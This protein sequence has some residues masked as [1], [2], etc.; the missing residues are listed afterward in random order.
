[1]GLKL[2]EIYDRIRMV[3]R[4]DYP[5]EFII[6]GDLKIELSK[7]RLARDTMEVKFVFKKLS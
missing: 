2:E 7:A 6:Y 5:N 3:D 4:A 1:M